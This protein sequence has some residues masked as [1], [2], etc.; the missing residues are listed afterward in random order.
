MFEVSPLSHLIA[1]T[2]LVWLG[3]GLGR[4]AA[5]PALRRART[6]SVA[7]LAAWGLVSS[8]IAWRGWYLALN[9]DTLLILFGVAAPILVLAGMLAFPSGRELV[10]R[11]ADETP[12]QA[13]ARIHTLR[14]LGIGA[15]YGWWI[16]EIPGHF[17]VPVGIPDLLIGLTAPLVAL[18]VGRDPAGSR[19]LFA[20]WNILG[21]AVLLQA[22]LW[23]Q[24]SQ[25][26]PLHFFHDGPR[27]DDVLSFP[28]A[29]V[30]TLVAPLFISVHAAALVQ[31]RRG[32]DAA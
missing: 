25:P 16:G 26:G 15:V 23:M 32:R 9:A 13:L 14:I 30:P 8:W 1:A 22:P 4:V 10:L 2:L 3:R 17:E 28:M 6:L 27:T 24:L 12:G 18:R 7:A 20:V 29:I 11:F 19:R 31:L 5:T 21:A